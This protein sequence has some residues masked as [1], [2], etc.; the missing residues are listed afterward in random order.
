VKQA[1]R[2]GYFQERQNRSRHRHRLSRQPQL[3]GRSQA[4]AD[5]S[6]HPGT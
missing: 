4:I 2:P 5:A 6:A 1:S 3:S